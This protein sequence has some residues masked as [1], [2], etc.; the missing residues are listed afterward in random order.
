MDIY[1]NVLR[2]ERVNINTN[3]KL[4]LFS[5]FSIVLVMPPP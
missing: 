4:K 2:N 1:G 3:V 5:Y